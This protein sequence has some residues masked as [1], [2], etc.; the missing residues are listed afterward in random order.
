MKLLPCPRCTMVRATLSSDTGARTS[1]VGSGL[2]SRHGNLLILNVEYKL[3][4]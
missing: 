1:G 2:P 4:P 3:N